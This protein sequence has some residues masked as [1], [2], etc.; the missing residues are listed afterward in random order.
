MERSEIYTKI[1]DIIVQVLPS[2]KK[3]VNSGAD[4]IANLGASSMDLVEIA[5]RIEKMFGFTVDAA[6]VIKLH[7]IDE[8]VDFVEQHKAGKTP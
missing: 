5:F 7:S 4:L 3:T 8:L 2:A 6:S 1:N